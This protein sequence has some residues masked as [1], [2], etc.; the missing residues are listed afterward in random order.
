MKLFLQHFTGLTYL[1]TKLP[2]MDD[3]II[4]LLIR[5]SFF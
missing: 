3:M 4:L 5:C 1:Y 2:A